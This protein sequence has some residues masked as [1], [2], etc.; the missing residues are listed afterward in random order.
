MISGPTLCRNPHSDYLLLLLPPPLLLQ[1]QPT[2]QARLQGG[3]RHGGRA[4]LAAAAG[5]E[6]VPLTRHVALV[7]RYCQSA[8]RMTCQHDMWLEG[9]HGDDANAPCPHQGATS[10]ALRARLAKH[11]ATT[12]HPC[13]APRPIYLGQA[14][15]A[16]PPNFHAQIKDEYASA[17]HLSAPTPGSAPA[18][19]SGA[20]SAS[21][22]TAGPAAA[23]NEQDAPVV[24]SR[25]AT[26]RLIES[27]PVK[28]RC[29][30]WGLL[31]P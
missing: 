21:A 28:D 9:R 11:L 27:I 29:G 7:R 30:C 13:T 19:V 20:V 2:H 17:Q 10:G 26:A 18:P 14:H 25:T 5:A 8:V 3:R 1:L 12:I 6:P 15:P 31:G 4:R 24:E 16:C 22:R 23:A